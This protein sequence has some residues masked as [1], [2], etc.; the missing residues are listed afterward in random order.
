MGAPEWVLKLSL[1]KQAYSD[2]GPCPCELIS[3]QLLLSPL[4]HL[5]GRQSLPWAILTNPFLAL[6]LAGFYG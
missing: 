4:T 2:V 1:D 3:P 6:M 5:S